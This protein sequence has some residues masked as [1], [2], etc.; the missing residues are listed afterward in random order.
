MIWLVIQLV[1]SAAIGYL[2]AGRT[3][4]ILL[5]AMIAVAMAIPIYFSYRKDGFIEF[6]KER[7]EYWK[8]SAD[9]WK[10][11]YYIGVKRYED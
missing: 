8:E 4:D 1:C 3:S 5:G 11:A 7:S 9:R 6:W 2:V 10:S